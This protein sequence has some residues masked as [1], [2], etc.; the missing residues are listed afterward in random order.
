LA[1]EQARFVFDAFNTVVTFGDELKFLRRRARLTQRQ[2][3]LAVG[4]SEAQICRL[5]QNQRQPDPITLAALFVPALGLERQPQLAARLLELATQAR[6]GQ[7]PSVPQ[8]MKPQREVEPEGS[9]DWLRQ[10]LV[11]ALSQV[12]TLTA[13]MR[14]LDLGC[15]RAASSVFLAREFGVQVWAADA[16]AEPAGNWRRA[17]DLGLGA[18]VY[19][20]QMEAHALPFPDCF[21]DAIVSLDA[22]RRFGTDDLYLGYIARF[23]RPEGQLGVV[24]PGVTTEPGLGPGSEA[25]AEPGS[26]SGDGVPAP[27]RS[28]WDPEYSSFHSP[29]WWAWHWARSGLV[30]V[31]RAD[32]IPGGWRDWLR[33]EHRAALA[34]ALARDAGRTLG[35]TRVVARRPG[36]GARCGASGRMLGGKAERR[37]ELVRGPAAPEHSEGFE[38][39]R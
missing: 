24:V 12:M 9:T 28:C 36:C 32:V 16:R 17:C 22:Y 20:L 33:W 15:D 31:E 18:L 37:A 23:L 19:P 5:E 34:E 11:E 1:T 7:K 35:F 13:G 29:R 3:G 2:L 38:D 30:E 10:R 26:G 21:F 39:R 25:G 14:V 8:E 4:Y 27:L 6:G